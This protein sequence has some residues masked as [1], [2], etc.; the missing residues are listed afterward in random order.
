M[1]TTNFP[2]G[3]SSFGIPIYGGPRGNLASGAPGVSLGVTSIIGNTWFVDTVFGADGNAGNSP[4]AAFSTMARAFLSLKS[5]DVI[6]FRGKI[7]ENLTTPEQV[8]DVWINGLGNRPR[9]ADATPLG[10]QY[11]AAQWAPAAAPTAGAPTL[12]VIQQGWRLS[13]FLMTSSGATAPCL[14]VSRNAGAGNAERDGSHLEVLGVR[15]AGAGIGIRSGEA[16]VFTEIPY[17]VLVAGCQFDGMTK[18]MGGI[19]GVT[20]NQWI[21]R[22]NFFM[23]NTSQIIMALTNSLILRNQIGPFTA[24]GNSGGIDLTGG[25]GTNQVNGNWLSGTYSNA[26][27]YVAGGAGDNWYGNFG[28][29]GVT[30][31]DPA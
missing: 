27:G 3:V 26:G 9:H 22:D 16:G 25:T 7:T 5:G 15:F 2:N 18:A 19:A 17:N 6:N 20:A 23:G 1:T 21:I 8:F 11:A 4:Q 30:S 24:A 10:G 31:A 13:N 29:A 14:Q 28:S 12:S